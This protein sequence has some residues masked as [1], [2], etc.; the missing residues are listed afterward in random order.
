MA[1]TIPINQPFK[2]P[3]PSKPATI[4]RLKK[5][6]ARAANCRASAPL[7]APT[8]PPPR[9]VVAMQRAVA[10]PSAVAAHLRVGV[11]TPLQAHVGVMAR[12]RPM[13]RVVKAGHPKT[14][15]A[16]PALARA[17]TIRAVVMPVRV[18]AHP[19]VDPPVVFRAE[20]AQAVAV[21][22]M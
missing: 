4:R 21:A 16:R 10:R 11:A 7:S 9:G 19:G 20:R 13:R 1:R 12:P 15:E 22:R 17:A 18:T 14:A 3:L 6:A 8:Q 5:H 2:T